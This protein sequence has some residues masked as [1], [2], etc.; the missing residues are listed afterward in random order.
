M[1]D[2][3]IDQVVDARG[4]ACP[5]PL[6]ELIKAVKAAE[7]GTVIELLSAEK[8]TTTD[9]PAWIKKVGQEYIS[10]AEKDGYWSIVVKKI[11]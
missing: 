4:S 2:L 5:G 3:K 1:S 11:K 10:T 7:V 6:M 9:A 8:G